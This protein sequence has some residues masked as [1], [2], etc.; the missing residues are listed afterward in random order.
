MK[1]IKIT[2][3]NLLLTT[4]LLAGSFLMA[5]TDA[6]FISKTSYGNYDIS[7]IESGQF[8]SSETVKEIAAVKKVTYDDH[9]FEAESFNIPLIQTDEEMDLLILTHK[10]IPVPEEGEGYVIQKL[11]HSRAFLNQTAF[12]ILN[13]ISAKFYQE[14]AKQLSISSLTRTNENQNKLRRVNSNATKKNSSHSYGASFDI[15]Y[16]KYGTQTGRNYANERVLQAILDD[17]VDQG[18][19]Y[20]IKERRQPCFHVTV[21]NT[22]PFD[23]HLVNN[24]K[25]P[26]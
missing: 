13:E 12:N 15:S 5:Q 25:N 3:K 7:S 18:K 8:T 2:M 19:I 14:T 11:T 6:T 24:E 26:V 23:S 4:S 20:Y 1:K 17:L 21:R 10:L 16:S 9:I 22:S